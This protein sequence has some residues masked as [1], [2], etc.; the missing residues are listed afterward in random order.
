MD[1]TEQIQRFQEFID[2]NC[3]DVLLENVRKGKKI[4]VLDFT[5]LS[6]HDPD[7]SDILLDQPEEV[8]RA[9][10]IAVEQFDLP[11]DVKDFKVRIKNV[12]TVAGTVH[13]SSH[14]DG[15]VLFQAQPLS[16]SDV[17]PIGP[18]DVP[19]PLASIPGQ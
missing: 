18:P 11:E 17:L 5:E 10:E 9:A 8:L 14:D 19:M 12:V 16:G 13:P 2:E 6:M 3:K 1:A 4:I 15:L 7:L